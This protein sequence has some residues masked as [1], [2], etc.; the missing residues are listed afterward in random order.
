M[1]YEATRVGVTHSVEK[2]ME[3]TILVTSHNP[4]LGMLDMPVA[5]ASP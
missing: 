1:N 2:H 3:R 4:S 5:L